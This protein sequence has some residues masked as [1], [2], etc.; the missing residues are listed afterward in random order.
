MGRIDYSIS[1]ESRTLD[2]LEREKNMM[3]FTKCHVC[4]GE[5]ETKAV[6]K[7]LRGDK[8]TAILNVSAEVCLH[9]GEKLYTEETVRYFESIRHKLQRQQTNEFQILGNSFTVPDNLAE[10]VL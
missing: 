9:C 3:P 4:G 7:V 6:E 8:H 10:R 5:L 2:K 1:S